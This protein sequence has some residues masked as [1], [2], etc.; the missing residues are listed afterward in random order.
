MLCF[1][2]LENK[3]A[4]MRCNFVMLWKRERISPPPFS[5][6]ILVLGLCNTEIMKGIRVW[7][8]HPF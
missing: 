6:P 1:V 2:S 7:F 8:P 5:S 3:E 4:K